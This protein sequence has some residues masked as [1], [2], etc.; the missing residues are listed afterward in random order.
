M[1]DITVALASP[2]KFEVS[3]VPQ[4][5]ALRGAATEFKVIERVTI[6]RVEQS[7]C[8]LEQSARSL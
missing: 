8:N 4:E 1:D 6:S 7:A 3:T 5:T 2:R